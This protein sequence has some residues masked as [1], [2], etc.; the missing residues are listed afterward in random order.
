MPVRNRCGVTTLHLYDAKE[1]TCDAYICFVTVAALAMSAQMVA[2]AKAE[3][4][5]VIKKDND[6]GQ[7]TT[8]FKKRQDAPPFVACRARRRRS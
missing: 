2:S 6:A 1:E 3:D 8:V 7:S 4:T 5:T